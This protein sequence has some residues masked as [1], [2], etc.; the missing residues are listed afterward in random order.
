MGCFDAHPI[1]RLSHKSETEAHLWTQSPD[2]DKRGSQDA[3]PAGR[4]VSWIQD[5]TTIRVPRSIIAN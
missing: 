1:W 4:V 5:L 2:A 3:L